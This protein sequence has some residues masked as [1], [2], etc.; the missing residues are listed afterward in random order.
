[1]SFTDNSLPAQEGTYQRQMTSYRRTRSAIL[2][3]AKSLVVLH[4]VTRTSMIEI[5][6][7]AQVS[8]ATLYN[9]FREKGSVI[10][11]LLESE[12]NRILELVTPLSSVSARL[13][14]L[15][16]QISTDPA[17]AK[18]RTADPALLTAVASNSTD[19][20]WERARSAVFHVCGGPEACAGAVGEIAILWLVG[21]LFHPLD[22]EASA[23]QALKVARLGA[24]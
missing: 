15:S 12:L 23:T 9:H 24:E 6:D 22:R 10:R 8:R 14:A 1:M 4:G 7:A 19:E 11:A 13:E 2:D 3:G 21:Q 20:L 5:A 16:I 17:I 18:L